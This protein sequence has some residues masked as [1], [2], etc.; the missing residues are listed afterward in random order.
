MKTLL[1]LSLV[2]ATLGAQNVST[3][4]IEKQVE[5]IKPARLGA[6]D[7]QI[8]ALKN[9]FILLEEAPATVQATE[10]L[11]AKKTYQSTATKSRY[12]HAFVLNATLNNSAKINNKWYVL[13]ATVGSYTLKQIKK[14]HIMLQR[15]QERPIAVYMHT[16][17]KNIQLT[18]K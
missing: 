9:P 5:E 12:I 3:E 14:D 17:N 4:W 10:K 15:G 7:A 1:L 16:K 6:S 18:T 8:M 13:N 2:T 11:R